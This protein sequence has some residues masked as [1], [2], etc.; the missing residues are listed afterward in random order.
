[1]PKPD[2]ERFLI[3]ACLALSPRLG[4]VAGEAVALARLL[5]ADLAVVHAGADTPDTRQRLADALALAGWDKSP[6]ISIEEG[7]PEAVIRDAAEALDADLVVAGSLETEGLLTGVFGSVSRRI[8]RTVPRSVILLTD[9][10]PKGTKLARIVV[11]V[12]LSAE[13]HPV[14]AFALGLAKRSGAAEVHIVH[15]VERLIGRRGGEDEELEFPRSPRAKAAEFELGEL[16][17]GYDRTGL[18]IVPAVLPGAEG[19]ETVDYAREHKADLVIFPLPA[20]S[21]GFWDRFFHHPAEV[22]L[23]RLPCALLFFRPGESG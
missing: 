14:L 19:L 4:N 5:D 23:E 7:K 20:R 16:L 6:R 17:A 8:V 1:M 11:S 13:A 2:S 15:G 9:P 18:Q 12:P 10:L 21:L 3:L 22:I